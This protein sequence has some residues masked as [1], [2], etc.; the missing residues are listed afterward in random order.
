M[1]IFADR[2]ASNTSFVAFV[3]DGNGCGEGF[4][5]GCFG[6]LRH[7]GFWIDIE[8]SLEDARAQ[9][10]IQA[11]VESFANEVRVRSHLSKGV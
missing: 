8:L 4:E 6:E 5:V 9:I 3:R 10:E 7:K 1:A 11:S 2:D